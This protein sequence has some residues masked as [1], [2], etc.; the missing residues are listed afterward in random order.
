[1]SSGSMREFLAASLLED[2]DGALVVLED[3]EFCFVF[4]RKIVSNF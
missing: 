4:P 3:E 2:G 1:M